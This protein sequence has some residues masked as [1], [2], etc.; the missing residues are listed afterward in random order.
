MIDLNNMAVIRINITAVKGEK[1]KKWYI[2]VWDFE[3]EI[4][5]GVRNVR[6]DINDSIKKDEEFTED[7]MHRALDDIQKIT[8]DYIKKVEMISAEKVEEIMTV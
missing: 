4:K 1:L 6:R 7:G 2:E 5:V 8:D 3:E